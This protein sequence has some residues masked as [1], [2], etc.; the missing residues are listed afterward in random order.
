MVAVEKATA[1]EYDLILMDI[2]MPH[3]DGI[4]ATKEIK[5]YFGSKSPVIIA[6]TANAMKDD[7]DRFLAAGMNDYLSK[8]FHYNDLIARIEKWT[9]YEVK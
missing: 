4:E 7:R 6:L 9:S 8:P 5:Q 1:S 2:N 3:K